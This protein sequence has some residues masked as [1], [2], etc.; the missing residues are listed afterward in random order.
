MFACLHLA[1]TTS[2]VSCLENF[3]CEI[4]YYVSVDT[5][6]SAYV[7]DRRRNSSVTV[8]SHRDEI[9]SS[10][11]TFVAVDYCDRWKLRGLQGGFGLGQQTWSV[12]RVL[13]SLFYGYKQISK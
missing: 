4:N 8:V 6:N 10:A 11:L 9:S 13:A 2:A 5:L 12:F 3:V 1:V 7:L